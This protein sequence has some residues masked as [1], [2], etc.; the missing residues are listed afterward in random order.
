MVQYLQCADIRYENLMMES[1]NDKVQRAKIEA[2]SRELRLMSSFDALFSQAVAERIGMHSTDIETMELLNILGPMTAGELSGRTGLSSGAT[3]RLIDRLEHAGLVR[4]RPDAT[5]RRRVI[6][7]PAYENLD[8]LGVL[9]YPMADGIAKIL[10]SYSAEQLDAFLE[11]IARC[12]A[13][14]AELNAEL[15]RPSD[16]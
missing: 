2:L 10:S 7:E 12:N 3:T 11:F 4:R 14:V 9:F 15:R 16:A 8:Q 5:D 6:I 13:L 1:T